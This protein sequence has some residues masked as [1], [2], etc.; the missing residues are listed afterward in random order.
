MSAGEARRCEPVERDALFGCLQREPAVCLSG[1]G[2]GYL[3]F[4]LKTDVTPSP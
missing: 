2:S 4:H 3:T 1:N